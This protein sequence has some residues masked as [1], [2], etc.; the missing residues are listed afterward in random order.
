MD[1]LLAGSCCVPPTALHT[2]KLSRVSSAHSSH[3]DEDLVK[4][5]KV[6]ISLSI[7]PGQG[8]AFKHGTARHN[9]HFVV[10]PQK[11]ERFYFD[12]VFSCQSVELCFGH[13]RFRSEH[14]LVMC[15]L[16][17]CTEQRFVALD[18]E[19]GWMATST[20]QVCEQGC[21]SRCF[22]P[23][24]SKRLTTVCRIPGRPGNERAQ[25]GL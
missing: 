21:F 5:I 8:C 7:S 25:V 18:R 16:G 23:L 22:N 14:K 12:F 15:M 4:A 1:F 17:V 20:Y 24:P 11:I 19:T 2:H 9:F 13:Q 3:R 6:A 10:Q